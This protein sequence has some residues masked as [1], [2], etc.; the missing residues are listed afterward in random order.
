MH[1]DGEAH[2]S[3]ALIIRSDIKHYEISKYQREFLQATSIV[4]EAWNGSIT[5][6]TIYSSPKYAIKREHYI[7]FF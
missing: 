1:P 2:G 6:S 7:I 5:I 4:V 3:T